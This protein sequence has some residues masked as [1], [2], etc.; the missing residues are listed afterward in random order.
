MHEMAFDLEHPEWREVD[1]HRGDLIEVWSRPVLSVEWLIDDR[2]AVM[3]VVA[4][5]LQPLRET[6][7]GG[8]N[9]AG[10]SAPIRLTTGRPGISARELGTARLI[11]ILAGGVELALV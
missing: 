11:A 5:N 6:I 1:A 4:S 2:H 9:Q 3:A 10:S 7:G 8:T